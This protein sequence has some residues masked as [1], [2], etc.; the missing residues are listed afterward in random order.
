MQAKLS[1]LE[2]EAY[3]LAGHTFS[4]TSVDDVV[5]VLFLELHL[6]PNGDA[7][8]PRSKK[9]LGYTR[10]GGGRARLG[11]HFS[12]TK[13]VLEKLRPLHP[14]PDVILEWRG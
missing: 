1:A 14:L 4:L 7:G 5:Q 13:D 2:S 10:R 11:K 6:P 9:T 3:S 8:G 12:T